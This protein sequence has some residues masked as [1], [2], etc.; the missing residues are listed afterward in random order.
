MRFLCDENITKKAFYLF[1]SARFD[2]ESVHSLNLK[3]I[4]NS[5]LLDICIEQN[6]ILITFD[7][8]FLHSS[9]TKFPGILL[10]RIFPNTDKYILPVLE[11]FLESIKE[12]EFQNK[13]VILEENTVFS[14]K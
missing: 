2:V 14:S 8:D 12:I 1:K 9:N 6:R 13:L 4:K 3:G 7:T 11:K 10:I 5:K